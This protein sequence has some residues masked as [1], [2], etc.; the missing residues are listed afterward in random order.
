MYYR[1]LVRPWLLLA[2]PCCLLLSSCQDGHIDFLGYTSKPNYD[3]EKYR[4]V[5]VNSIEN[6]TFYHDLDVQ[7]QTSLVREIQEKAHMKVVGFGCQADTELSITINSLNKIILNRTQQNETREAQQVL[8]V[9]VV[10]KDLR[11]NEILSDPQRVTNPATIPTIQP[12]AGGKATATP[13]VTTPNEEDI[14]QPTPFGQDPVPPP[15]PKVIVRSV[16]TVIPELGVS[17]AAARQSNADR[18]AVEIVSMMESAW[19]TPQRK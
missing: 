13:V 8:E 3:L 9:A 16:A 14:P 12:P 4:T 10:W 17:N 2:V 6:R 11:T 1:F 19:P 18:L 15:A 7:L 5:R